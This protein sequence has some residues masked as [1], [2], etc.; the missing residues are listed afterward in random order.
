MCVREDTSSSVSNG[1]TG[2]AEHW[3]PTDDPC[4]P[5]ANSFFVRDKGTQRLF[6]SVHMLNLSTTVTSCDVFVPF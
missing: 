5:L 2:G 3:A 1:E 4:S 6:L